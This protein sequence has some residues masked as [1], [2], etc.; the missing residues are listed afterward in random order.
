MK[1]SPSDAWNERNSTEEHSVRRKEGNSFRTTR[2]WKAV[3]GATEKF[4]SL[5]TSLHPSDSMRAGT[6]VDYCIIFM[7]FHK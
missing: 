4:L 6:D 2:P 7:I 5:G 3:D 1:K